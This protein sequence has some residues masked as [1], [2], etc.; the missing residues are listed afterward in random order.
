MSNYR[1]SSKARKVENTVG[2][3]KKWIHEDEFEPALFARHI[4]DVFLCLVEHIVHLQSRLTSHNGSY[5]KTN[6]TGYYH[7]FR[8]VLFKLESD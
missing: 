3:R 4:I 2:V 8:T 1:Q 6:K 7:N 5:A